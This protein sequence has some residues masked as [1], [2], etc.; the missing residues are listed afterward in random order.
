M[1]RRNTLRLP[2]FDYS[3]ANA[4]YVTIRTYKGFKIFGRVTKTGMSLNKNGRIKIINEC[5]Q[6]IGRRYNYID[7]DEFII[8]PNHLHG[9]L[10]FTEAEYGGTGGSRTALTKTISPRKTL[11]K[12]FCL[13]KRWEG[14]SGHLRRFPLK[15]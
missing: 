12:Q 11:R 7:L 9:I 4:Y 15:R 3:S 13:E 14:L 2:E 8:M 10:L 1:R 5:W 6:Q